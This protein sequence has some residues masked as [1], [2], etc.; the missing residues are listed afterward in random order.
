MRNRP[1]VCTVAGLVCAVLCKV[2]DDSY[3]VPATPRS[4][5]HTA[6]SQSSAAAAS[7]SAPSSAI[8]ARDAS[9]SQCVH[10]FEYLLPPHRYENG[11]PIYAIAADAQQVYFRNLTQVYRVPLTG[12]QATV[13][14]QGPTISLSTHGA[15]FISGERLLT[16][17]MGESV[18]MAAPKSGGEWSTIIDLTNQKQD[19]S[20]R[21]ASDADFDGSNFYWAIGG[22]MTR[23]SSTASTLRTV[24]LSGAAP[25]TL[26]KRTGQMAEV[27]RAGERIVFMHTEPA[28]AEQRQ[29]AVEYRRPH[30]QE[31]P[32]YGERLLLSVPVTGGEAK[33]LA[34]VSRL[35][36]DVVL[37]VDGS[38]VY[39][40]GELDHDH[41]KS[42]IFKLD[43]NGSSLERLDE[44][45]LQGRAL[46]AGSNVIF[47][48]S[49]ELDPRSGTAQEAVFSIPR[50]GNQPTFVACIPER[51]SVA[52]AVAGKYL[53]MSLYNEP[54][55]LASIAKIELP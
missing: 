8:L 41:T 52:Y 11:G 25:Q 18:F 26:Y 46:V 36:A 38:S 9:S 39:I 21:L 45:S 19:E 51:A 47:A 5:Q 34:H 48:G 2:K 31:F 6:L 14:S 37:G 33:I 28:S 27:T 7:S 42:G 55:H 22:T 30:V 32:I 43:A 1:L 15:I 20:A 13:I 54:T 24:A 50:G 29:R 16:Q 53:L 35:A 40:S 12:G 23:G 3:S 4:L 17:A 44:R 10:R 49:I